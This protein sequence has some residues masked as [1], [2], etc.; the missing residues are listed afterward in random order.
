MI[1]VLVLGVVGHA[2]LRA[3]GYHATALA[4][5]TSKKDAMAQSKLSYQTAMFRRVMTAELPMVVALTLSF[6][7]PGGFYLVLFGCAVS[8]NLLVLHVWPSERSVERVKKA[9]E[10]AGTRSYLRESLGLPPD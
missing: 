3:T 1:G 5:G 8:L 4:R 9:L 10:A 7:V 2:I 6:T